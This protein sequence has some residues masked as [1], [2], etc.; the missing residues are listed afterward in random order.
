MAVAKATLLEPL[1]D[2]SVEVTHSGLVV[3]GGISGLVAA[4]ELADQGY[5][6]YLVDKSSRLL[7]GQA[8]HLNTTWRGEDIETYLSGLIKKVEDH[9]LIKT[10]L[11]HRILEA[12]GFVGQFKTRLVRVDN[13][14]E[15]TELQH[16]IVVIATGAQELKPEEYAYGQDPRV[17]THLELDQKMAGKDPLVEKAQSVVIHSMRGVPRA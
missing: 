9:P 1:Q 8:L 7:A 5:Q 14:S 6:V 4:L 16:G 2:T 13:G 12:S 10:Y 15:P 11:G 17:M 3:G